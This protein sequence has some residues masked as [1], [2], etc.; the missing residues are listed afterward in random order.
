ML[1]P[2]LNGSVAVSAPFFNGGGQVAGSLSVYGPSA[3][4][5]DAQIAKFGKL[6]VREAREISQVLGRVHAGIGR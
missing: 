6:L 1:R 4:L 3:R 2:G 5:A